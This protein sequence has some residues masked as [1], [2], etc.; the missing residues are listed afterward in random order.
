MVLGVLGRANLPTN[1]LKIL[2]PVNSMF[3]PI[4]KLQCFIFTILIFSFSDIFYIDATNKQTLQV[5]L[6]A[7]VPG[8]VE[9]SV[10]TSLHWLACQHDRKWLLF[11]D[12]ADDVDL[13]LGKFIPRSVFGNTLVTTRNPDVCVITGVDGS[14][15]VEGMSVEDSIDL[16]LRISC[17]EPNGE[18]QILAEQIVTVCFILFYF[19]NKRNILIAELISE[20]SFLCFGSLSSRCLHSPLSIIERVSRTLSSE[21]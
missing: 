13:D 15:K 4:T 16:L 14:R 11:F 12:N 7:I 3:C 21:T 6:E 19:P 20:T 1:S 8:T 18:N 9:P 5:D 2:N 10:D 17:T